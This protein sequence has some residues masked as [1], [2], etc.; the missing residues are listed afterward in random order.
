V[1]GQYTGRCER[2]DVHDM[3]VH[4][5]LHIEGLS[6]DGHS[7]LMLILVCSFDTVE[8]GW[9]VHVSEERAASIFRVKVCRIRMMCHT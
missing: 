9:V 1:H 3:R 6:F 2:H 5:M 4:L 8:V 7:I